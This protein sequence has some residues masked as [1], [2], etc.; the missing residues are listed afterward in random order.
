VHARRPLT[1]ATLLAAAFCP[2]AL[3][4]QDDHANPWR[5]ALQRFE[6]RLDA[7][8]DDLAS[9][10]ERPEAPVGILVPPGP[11]PDE[12]RALP[13]AWT[14]LAAIDEPPRRLVLL[15]H[16]LD[17]PGDIWCDL[18]PALVEAGHAVSRF[19]YPNDQRVH[20]SAAQL[21]ESLDRARDAGVE[22]IAIIGHSMG[23]LVAFDALTR[24]D[25]YAGDISGT[26]HLP[27][28]TRLI[29]VGT[30]WRG[31]PWSR[32]R[33]AAEVREQVQRWLMDE[34]WDVR[35]LLDYRRDGKGQ[36]G[37][38]LAEGSDLIRALGQ[39][40]TPEGLPLTIIAGRIAPAGPDDLAWLEQ[41]RIVRELFSEEDLAEFIADIAETTQTLGDGA[42][43]LDS[44]LARETDDVAVFEVNHRALIRHSPL[45]F[46]TGSTDGG[47]PGI[48]VILER[49]AR[50]EPY[51]PDPPD[52]PD[53]PAPNDP[54]H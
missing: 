46:L 29:A 48:A 38:D 26:A 22:E 15:V 23:G 36:A 5:Q 37:D 13:A 30:P 50:D 21:L 9:L 25:G 42:V 27:R 12:A 34:S 8:L 2:G 47:P 54:D 4:Q 44:A 45:D 20:L 41:S 3:G 18:A 7:L 24:E 14:S 32:L 51:E 49:L 52:E 17:E 43:P 1:L 10:D 39:R 35:P 19:E 16:G 40:P 28:V 53:E 33:A 6:L 31:S 11:A